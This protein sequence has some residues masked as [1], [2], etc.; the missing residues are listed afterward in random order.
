MIEEGKRMCFRK[1][2]K[3]TMW[4][5]LSVIFQGFW[6]AGLSVSR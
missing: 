4:R 5:V 3:D 1:D 6:Q 2:Y